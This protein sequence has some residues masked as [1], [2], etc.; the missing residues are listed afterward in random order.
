MEHQLIAALRSLAAYGPQRQPGAE[1]PRVNFGQVDVDTFA[2]LAL[3]GDSK[4]FSATLVASGT[5]AP[6]MTESLYAT[7]F[8]LRVQ[9]SCTRPATRAEVLAAAERAP[10]VQ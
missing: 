10:L 7:I 6:E 2:A 4:P 5:A 1:A 9:A 8:G 3:A